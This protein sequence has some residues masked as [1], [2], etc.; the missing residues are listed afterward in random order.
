MTRI[1]DEELLGIL[2]RR[3]KEYRIIKGFSQYELSYSANIPRSQV[4]RIENGEVNTTISSLFT[5]SKALEINLQE[6]FIGIE[7][8]MDNSKKV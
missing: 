5:I 2:G 7:Q 8:H 6:L 1:K 4:I 3:V